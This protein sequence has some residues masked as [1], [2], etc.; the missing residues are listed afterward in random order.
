MCD[1]Y[2]FWAVYKSGSVAFDEY[3]RIATHSI[4]T[5]ISSFF[6][7]NQYSRICDRCHGW[8]ILVDTTTKTY[9]WTRHANTIWIPRTSRPAR[10]RKFR[11]PRMSRPT[12]TNQLRYRALLRYR[13][14]F[15]IFYRVFLVCHR[16]MSQIVGALMFGSHWFHGTMY[17]LKHLFLTKKAIII[18]NK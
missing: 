4:Y 10:T 9:R 7:R 2:W 1:V 13:C 3:L 16:K 14:S 5:Y 11:S 17:H 18:L 6:H 15:S 8:L 12:A